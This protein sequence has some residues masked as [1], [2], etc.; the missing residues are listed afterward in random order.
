MKLV[1]TK[2]ITK[3]WN[4]VFIDSVPIYNG[5]TEIFT[6]QLSESSYRYNWGT[7]VRRSGWRKNNSN[8]YLR[9][10]MTTVT[11]TMFD[12]ICPDI[13]YWKRRVK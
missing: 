12:K 11:N 8:S 9:F 5:D 4:K 7:V 6:I 2:K 13:L 1:K 3:S 10:F